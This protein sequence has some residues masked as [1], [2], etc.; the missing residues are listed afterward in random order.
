M[1]KKKIPLKHVLKFTN[2]SKQLK[3]GER[4]AVEIAK[5]SHLS[6]NNRKRKIGT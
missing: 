5:L 1:Y 6:A 4:N 3:T 2:K